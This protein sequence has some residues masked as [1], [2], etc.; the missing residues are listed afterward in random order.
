MP[1]GKAPRTPLA[2]VTNNRLPPPV[3]G[4]ADSEALGGSFMPG[5]GQPRPQAGHGMPGPA[6]GARSGTGQH[7]RSGSRRP[8]V[9]NYQPASGTVGRLR[10]LIISD[11]FAH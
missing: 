8:A 9:G 7:R 10:P 4:R 1:A 11:P 3:A 5:L 6:A 2:N